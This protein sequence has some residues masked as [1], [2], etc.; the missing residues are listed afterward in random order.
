[1]AMTAALLRALLAPVLLAQDQPVRHQERVDVDRVVVEVRVLDGRG[2]PLRGLGQ[3]EFAL[4]VDGRPVPIESVRWI[5]HAPPPSESAGPA[6]ETEA[7]PVP[8]R[9]LV[10]LF[11][12]DLEPT[13]AIG[14]LRIQRHARELIDDLSPG[15]LV[16]VASHDSRLRLWLD[17]TA[18]RAAARWAVEHSVLFG[19][20]A[21]FPMSGDRSLRRHLDGAAARRAATPESALLTLGRAL[22]PLPG[23]KAVVLFGWGMGRLGPMGVRLSHEYDEALAALT[24]A[25]ASV[26]AL[27]ITDADW[28]SL[29]VGLQKVAADTGGTYARTHLFPAAAV[30]RLEAALSGHYLLSFARP[31][32]PHG[33]HRLRVRLSGRRGNV[34]ARGTYADPPAVP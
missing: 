31:R 26:F 28:H 3:S 16:A 5:E 2:R 30:R 18:D 32:L 10:L 11:Q 27:D 15:D 9:L 14:L 17:F 34:L 25:G 20:A 7:P 1:M 29:E 22:T 21:D 4:E 12:K 8:G 33:E 6:P 24:D 19:R 13:R 23:T